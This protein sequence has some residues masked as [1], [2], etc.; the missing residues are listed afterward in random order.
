MLIVLDAN[1]TFLLS[2]NGDLIQP[3]AGIVAI[4]AGGPYAMAA[5]KALARHTD[6]PA[7]EIA[8]KAM[9]IAG[10]ICIYTNANGTIEEL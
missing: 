4:G 6:L 3:D 2:G 9:E 7:R 5:A 10:A 1:G 8:A